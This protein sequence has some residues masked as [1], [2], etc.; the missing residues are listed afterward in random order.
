MAKYVVLPIIR[1]AVEAEES[2]FDVVRQHFPGWEPND[3]DEMTV[4]LRA[5]AVM[6]SD[7]ATLS[8]QMGAE[9]FRYFGRTVV[10]LPPQDEVSASGT[11][12]FTLKDTNG[13]YIIPE[14]TEIAGTGPLG[15][16]ITFATTTA[17][18]SAAGA[19]TIAGVPVAATIEG[20]AGNGV[21]GPGEF[22]EF[23]DYLTAVTFDTPTLGG[24]D[25]ESDDDYL[26]RLAT[27]TELFARTPIRASDFATL[28]RYLAGAGVRATAIDMLNPV[29]GSVSDLATVT[30]AFVDE[31]GEA[32]PTDKRSSV[33]AQLLALREV[34][35]AVYGV[36]PTYTAFDVSF[37]GTS[38]PGRDPAE[39]DQAVTDV[40]REAL[41]PARWGQRLDTGETL[42]WFND[43]VV[44]YGYLVSRM[45]SV[46]GLWKGDLT[47]AKS[48]GALGTGNQ[49]MSGYAPLPRP[50]TVQGTVVEGG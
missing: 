50:G 42:E 19:S 40:L 41:S 4:L 8:T 33:V 9:G 23:L 26:D 47:F 35:F 12:T 30:V 32:I 45:M 11:A 31:S 17:R 34:G 27:H 14:G 21:V 10:Q 37:V 18:A 22:V 20:A 2:A 36:D 49:T 43:P 29:T 7:V 48:G 3:A 24:A 13:P 16:P 46:E 38:Y 39:V 28:G 15:E 6:Y 5:A 25:R 44:T 1:D